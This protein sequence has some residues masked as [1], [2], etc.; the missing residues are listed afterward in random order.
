MR[1]AVLL[2]MLALTGLL[3]SRAGA[4]PPCDVS[5]DGSAGT[6]WTEPD[7]WST[8]AVPAAGQHVC[9]PAA[10]TAVVDSGEQT[11][12][13]LQAPGTVEVVSNLSLTDTSNDSSVTTLRLNGGTVGGPADLDVTGALTWTGGTFAGTGTTRLAAGSTSTQSGFGT[14]A[15][16]HTLAAAGTLR[17]IAS[18]GFDYVVLEAGARLE[19]AGILD[20][21][22]ATSIA[23]SGFDPAPLLANTGTLRH[24]DAGDVTITVPVANAGTIDVQAGRLGLYAGGGPDR[25]AGHFGASTGA[26]TLGLDAGTFSVGEGA[27]FAGQVDVGG[28]LDLAGTVPSSGRFALRSGTLDG[29]GTLDVR[30]QLD[31]T[32]GAMTG[33]GTTRLAPGS[34]ADLRGF[35]QLAR[36]LRNES[37]LRLQETEDFDLLQMDGGSVLDNDGT[38]EVSSDNGISWTGAGEVARIDNAGTLRRP[39]QL[40]TGDI[41]VAVSGAGAVQAL[42]ELRLHRGGT[43]SGPLSGRLRLATGTFTL[44]AGATLAGDVISTGET[45]VTATVP[46]TGTFTLSSGTLAGSGTLEIRGALTWDGGGM[47]GSGTTRLIG[48]A[49]GE[50]THFVSLGEGR[51]LRNEGTLRL[52][53]DP[54]NFD[55]IQVSDD[56]K[57]DNAGTLELGG[58]FS[59]GRGAGDGLELANSGTLRKLAAGDLSQIAVPVTGGGTIDAAG[60]LQLSGGGSLSGPLRGRIEF[61][62]GEFALVAPATLDGVTLRN[63]TVAV[64]GTIVSTGTL[65]VV[66]G[67]IH[68]DGTLEVRGALAWSAGSMTGAGTTRIAAGATATLSGFVD[69]SGRTLRNEGALRID[70]PSA[71]WSLGPGARLEN[72]ASLTLTDGS[73]INDSSGLQPSVLIN[74]GTITRAAG[75]G[76]AMVN[77]PVDNRG[78]ITAPAG[79]LTL[80]LGTSRPATGS[81]GEGAGIVSLTSGTYQ[82]AAGARLAGNVRVDGTLELLANVLS[83]GSL[84]LGGTVSGPGRLDVAGSLKWTSGTMTGRGVTRI[85]PTGSLVIDGPTGLAGDRTLRNEGA[86]RWLSNFLSMAPDTLLENVGTLDLEANT[87]SV[88]S[89][90]GSGAEIHNSG[91]IRRI[92]GTGV[93]DIRTLFVNDGTLDV[94]RGTLLFFEPYVQSVDGVLRV[95]I[96]GTTPGTGFGTVTTFIARLGGTLQIAARDG[97]VPAVGDRLPIVDVLDRNGTFATVVGTDA[98]PGRRWSV[99]YD[100]DAVALIA[101]A[102]Q[103]PAPTPALADPVEPAVSVAPVVAAA[104]PAVTAPR[105]AAPMASPADDR[106]TVR[107]GALLRLGAARGLLAND[108]AASSAVVRIVWRNRA[109][110]AVRIDARTGALRF[111]AGERGIARLRYRLEFTDGRRSPMATVTIRSPRR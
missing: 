71:Y 19:N 53:D 39:A 58:G 55:Y 6:S 13:S 75:T 17:L 41:A 67:D 46:S 33:S 69:L 40:G 95:E 48:S 47:A 45:E 11:I 15:A 52:T 34:S 1:V 85:L 109:A 35:L 4:A 70:G 32:G 99:R 36:T 108:R 81:F 96:G 91:V 7:N 102:A 101:E 92:A 9:V 18:G 104:A 49:T 62:A 14:I 90:F 106:Y 65:T 3:V 5:F 111:R 30:G 82:L 63:G 23:A 93:I 28:T 84:E 66:G 68:G 56:A 107:P 94:R 59:I 26:G 61:V 8:G 110:R 76:D 22:A 2:C 21:A 88:S 27:D 74:T 50:I 37:T 10:L 78:A 12:A 97:Y 80:G 24:T 38:L 57:L 100:P 54:E 83:P 89:Y 60:E 103:E 87:G 29:V 25:M 73:M 72:A 31:W 16:G 44:S 43:F 79:V 98:G 105:A 77:A 20:L 51:T 64:T 42:S 86:A